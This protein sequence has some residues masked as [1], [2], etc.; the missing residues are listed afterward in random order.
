MPLFLCFK[1]S[2]SEINFLSGDREPWAPKQKANQLRLYQP[3]KSL[4]IWMKQTISSK[5]KDNWKI[6][7]MKKRK[8]Y[9]C[10]SFKIPSTYFNIFF[11]PW[12]FSFMQIFQYYVKK[13]LFYGSHFC[14]VT[15]RV[16][17]LSLV[18]NEQVMW[19]MSKCMQL[20][21]QE[22]ATKER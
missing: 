4:T 14:H 5:R 19:C 21:R 17:I 6:G 8:K 10:R 12:D 15:N 9:I 3:C 11:F 7:K 16:D 13:G 20:H 22:C 18:N 1:I 2:A